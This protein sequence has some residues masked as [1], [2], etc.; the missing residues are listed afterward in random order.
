LEAWLVHYSTDYV[1]D[2]TKR[3]P[4]VETDAPNP[5]NAYGRA[6]LA[7]EQAVAAQA[8]HYLLLRL[9]WVYGARGQNFLLTIRR[10]AR[11]RETLR[12]VRDQIGCPTWARMV[13]EA[14]SLALARVLASADPGQFSGL[15]HLAA[16]GE[17]SWHAFAQ[18]IVGLMP[19][20]GKKCNTVQAITTAQYPTAA[21]RPAY[22][23]L[24]C[25]KLRRVFGLTLPPWEDGLKMVGDELAAVQRT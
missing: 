6:K 19:P 12:V 2:G 9:C 16:S 22:S 17:T 1:F 7:G 5:L 20:D 24:G 4:Y 14:T 23:V 15:Y 21:P 10:L 25:D 18:A 11:E 13:A 3:S 8:G